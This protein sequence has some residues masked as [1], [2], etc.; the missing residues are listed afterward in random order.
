MTISKVDKAVFLFLVFSLYSSLLLAST[1]VTLCTDTDYWYPYSYVNKSGN[2]AGL[3]LDITKKALENLGYTVNYKAMSREDCLISAQS[4]MVD[5]VVSAPYKPSQAEY[6]NYPTDADSVEESPWRVTQVAYVAVVSGDS[7]YEFNGNIASLPEPVRVTDGYSYESLFRHTELKI[8]ESR[9]GE[10]R[11]IEKLIRSKK[12]TVITTPEVF[13]SL[14]AKPEYQGKIK[15][16]LRPLTSKS[17][18]VTFAKG[19]A[20]SE[21]TQS[22]IWQEI[23]R[24]RDGEDFLE[25]TADLLVH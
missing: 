4:N 2:A 22:A 18:Y 19:S 12:G 9:S 3:H 7:D 23:A 17:Y 5:G 8:Y 25:E 10:L 20:L 6:L 1:N 21:E 13:K 11:N 16:E 24:L 15:S 14:V